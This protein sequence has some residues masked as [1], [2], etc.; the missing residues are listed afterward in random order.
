MK[1]NYLKAIEGFRAFPF[2]LNG[3]AT[4]ESIRLANKAVRKLRDAILVD[5]ERA[6]FTKQKEYQ[7]SP[8]SELEKEVKSMVEKEEEVELTKEEMQNLLGILKNIKIAELQKQKQMD[9]NNILGLDGFMED[10]E[11]SLTK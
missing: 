4:L 9:T 7:K 11:S 1:T 10:L 3:T 2:G 6:I 5:S 8:S